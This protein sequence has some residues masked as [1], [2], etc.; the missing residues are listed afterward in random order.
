M[1]FS[2]ALALA[3]LLMGSSAYAVD[4]NACRAKALQ[5]ITDEMNMDENGTGDYGYRCIIT[6]TKLLG[7]S[8]HAMRVK[9]RCSNGRKSH[10]SVSDLCC[11]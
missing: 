10:R 11:D 5:D 9:A 4:Y 2:T 7:G 3:I 1:R 8:C 6:S